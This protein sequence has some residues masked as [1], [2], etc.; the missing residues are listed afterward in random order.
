MLAIIRRA[1]GLW[2]AAVM[3]GTVAETITDP[4]GRFRLCGLPRER[5]TLFAVQIGGTGASASVDAG[6]DAIVD[7]EIAPK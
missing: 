5:I 7:I 4:A 2:E 1:A 6:A 3:D